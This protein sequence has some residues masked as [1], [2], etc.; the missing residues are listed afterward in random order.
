MLCYFAIPSGPSFRTAHTHT[1]WLP[2][3]VRIPPEERTP[4]AGQAWIKVEGQ[5]C[6][7][8]TPVTATRTTTKHEETI[9]RRLPVR[10]WLRGRMGATVGNKIYDRQTRENDKLFDK[11][12][13]RE[14]QLVRVGEIFP[15]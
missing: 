13:G 7:L 8:P 15:Q 4:K 6:S 9:V 12:D 14:L 2:W 5:E 3:F 1:H 10:F 11:H